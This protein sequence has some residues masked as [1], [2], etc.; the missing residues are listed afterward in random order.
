MTTIEQSQTRPGLG[1]VPLVH[2][3]VSGLAAGVVFGVL[4][5][6]MDMMPMVASLVG[7]SSAGLGWVVHLAISALIGLS[8]PLAFGRWATNLGTSI[9]IG[10]VYGTVWWVL[11]ALILMPAKLGMNVLVINELALQSLMGHL[12]FGMVLGGVYAILAR[13]STH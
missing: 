3:V 2:G 11:G 10:A 13:R 6:M 9:A 4:M 5:Q 8:F 12:M 1:S 7:G